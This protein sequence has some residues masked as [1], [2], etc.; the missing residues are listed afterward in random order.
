MN[1]FLLSFSCLISLS[2][3]SQNTVG[4]TE[5]EMG[6]LDGY[7]LF[8]PMPSTET[9]LIDKCGEKVH[10]W[11]TSTYRPALSTF[12]LEDGSL[13]RT[14][15]LDNPDFDEG[16]SGGII[17]RFDWQGNLTWSYSISNAN[18]CLHHDIM[19]LPNGN[20]LCIVWDRY[21]KADGVAQGM[22][23]AYPNPYIWSEKIVELQPVGSNDAVVVWEWKLWDH[24]VQDLDNT[25][26]N[27]GVVADHHE[28]VDLN[29]FP[30]QANGPDWVHLNSVDYNSDINQILLSSHTFNE[31]WIIDHSTST[32]EAASSSNGNAGMGG[33]LL[34]R[35][36]N[37]QTYERGNPT[38]KKLYAQHHATWI[39][40]GYPNEG[41]I[42]V[43]NNGLM[44]PGNYSSIDII[45]PPFDGLYNYS[46]GSSTAYLPTDLFWTYNANPAS[47]F[48]SSNISGVYALENG[49][50]LITD[51]RA[52]TFFEVN[53]NSETLWKY[54]SPISSSG[55]A[56]Q[57]STVTNNLVFRAN[58]YPSNYAGFAG[59]NLISA[60]EIELNPT[61]PSLCDVVQN[62]SEIE[63][64][65]PN[66]LVYPNP[67]SDVLYIESNG[68]AIHS[69]ELTDMLGKTV[70]VAQSI[71]QLNVSLLPKGVYSLSVHFSD[72][73]ARTFRIVR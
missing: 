49:S 30:S 31:V 8:S 66:V 58:Y 64:A 57:G 45:E 11:T 43:F 52:G 4:L 68:A 12:L 72:I 46:I 50:F 17:E 34:Y 63:Q 71:S 60:G 36:G 27:F 19:P 6:N 18:N 70:Y 5:F 44:R 59:Q 9:F 42:L 67:V 54:V 48:Y 25:K 2:A 38:T 29:Y 73:E 32:S 7:V 26:P 10:E 15:K 28:L 47:D 16:G 3:F 62:S 22:N 61:V 1:H 56:A 33:D 20:I 41:K 65:E 13:L 14:G 23:P 21:T 37:P 39:P 55:V 35:W 53:A 40:E 51:G 24:L 69:I